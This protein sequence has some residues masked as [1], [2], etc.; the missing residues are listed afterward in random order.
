MA[1]KALELFMAERDAERSNH[2]RCDRYPESPPEQQLFR[3]GVY[4]S[5]RCIQR[6]NGLYRPYTEE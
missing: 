1:G 2:N 3:A 5:M 6:N 4:E